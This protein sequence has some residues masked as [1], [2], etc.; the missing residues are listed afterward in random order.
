MQE[1]LYNPGLLPCSTIETCYSFPCPVCAQRPAL[2]PQADRREA[3]R[4]KAQVG[5]PTPFARSAPGYPAQFPTSPPLAIRPAQDGKPLSLR[6]L[7]SSGDSGWVYPPPAGFSPPGVSSD[8]P[9]SR[10]PAVPAACFT[11]R[12][13]TSPR[14]PLGLSPKG[15]EHFRTAGRPIGAPFPQR[16]L[17]HQPPASFPPRVR[18]PRPLP[19]RSPRSLPA[20]SRD[21]QPPATGRSATPTPDPLPERAPRSIL[22]PGQG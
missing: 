22:T 2:E 18:E 20:D 10:R 11:A 7:N 5:P 12:Y 14:Q 9:T 19:E 3:C 13:P 4:L 15:T 8:A 1:A 6:P 21:D 16:P 17:P